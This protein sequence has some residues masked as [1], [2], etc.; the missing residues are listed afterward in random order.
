MTA[1]QRKGSKLNQ[2]RKTSVKWL[3][4]GCKTNVMAEPERK[5]GIA[6]VEDDDIPRPKNVYGSLYLRLG[7]VR[8]SFLV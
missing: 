1:A 8:K 7:A 5:I 4:Q 6:E 2:L 3:K